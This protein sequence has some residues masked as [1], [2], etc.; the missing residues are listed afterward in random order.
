[1][2]RHSTPLPQRRTSTYELKNRFIALA[3]LVISLGALALTPLAVQTS[4]TE[5]LKLRGIV[6]IQDLGDQP[7][8][9]AQWAGTKGRSLRLEGFAIDFSP[10]VPGLGLEYMCHLQ[11]I[12]D[13]KWMPGGSFCGTRG[14]ERRVEGFAIR[15]TGSQISKYNVYY[16]CHVQDVGDTGQV[17]NGA[18]CGTHGKSLRVEA[19]QVGVFPKEALIV[20]PVGVSTERRQIVLGNNRAT[21]GEYSIPQAVYAAANLQCVDNAHKKSDSRSP[22]GFRCECD[23]GYASVPGSQYPDAWGNPGGNCIGLQQGGGNT[24]IPP[25]SGPSG[26]GGPDVPGPRSPCFPSDQNGLGSWI[27]CPY[28]LIKYAVLI[29]SCNKE[30]L[31]ECGHS[32]PCMHCEQ[33][34]DSIGARNPSEAQQM[35]IRKKDPEAYYNLGKSC[36]AASL[37]HVFKQRY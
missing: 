24:P 3:G 7:L 37:S 5:S 14:E 32:Y 34:L 18:F 25:P 31:A 26:P 10:P 11:D 16:T 21:G 15:L 29:D 23:S 6:H 17:M 36:W 2:R 9:A 20:P 4:L 8:E 19:L 27:I 13:T 35:C 33:Y 22:V 1:M 12:G 28:Y 30:L